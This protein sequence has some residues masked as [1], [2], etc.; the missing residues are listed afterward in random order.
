MAMSDKI[1]FAA[2]T[3][4]P[5]LPIRDNHLALPKLSLYKADQKETLRNL[6]NHPTGSAVTGSRSF[7]LME[8]KREISP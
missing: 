3:Q 1:N 4:L 8:E 6:S 5:P 7:R 2:K